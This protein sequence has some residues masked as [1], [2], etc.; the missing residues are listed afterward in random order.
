MV[1]IWLPWLAPPGIYWRFANVV[2]RLLARSVVHSVILRS[3]AGF[4]D[5]VL[6]NAPTLAYLMEHCPNLKLLSLKDLAMDENHCHVLAAYSRPDLE[7]ILISCKLTSAGASALVEVLG[8]N[9][10]PTELTYCNIECLGLLDR[11]HGNSRLKSFTPRLSDFRGAAYQECLVIASGSPDDANRPVL[12]IAG[13]LKENTGL[14]V[15]D[16]GYCSL[17]D[18]T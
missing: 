12:A 9:Q 15:F 8:R 6:I 11:L 16:L 5:G 14:V 17:T 13:I 1:K 3:W 4:R 18:K 7:I 2:L 10:R